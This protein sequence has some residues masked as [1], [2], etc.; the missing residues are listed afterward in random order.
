MLDRLPPEARKELLDLAPARPYVTGSVLLRQGD[1][2]RHALIVRATGPGAPACVKVTAGLPNGAEGLLGI[3]VCGDIV[4]E[5]AALH[6][7]P[8][9][10]NVVACSDLYA[11]VI[12]SGDLKVFL[13]RFPEAWLALSNTIADRLEWANQRRLD[14]TGYSVAVRLARV[15]LL[16]ADRH[17]RAVE[18]GTTLGVS[19]SHEELGMLIGARKDAVFQALSKLRKAG[20]ITSA[21]RSV[22]IVDD[23]GLRRF[24][25]SQD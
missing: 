25:G 21:Y 16:L 13:S 12:R 10:A 6:G 11:H 23:A 1:D 2:S 24:A 19:L 18:T 14:F 4:G 8:R 17:G 3:R 5:L 7:T 9:S 15:V 22:V 20:Y